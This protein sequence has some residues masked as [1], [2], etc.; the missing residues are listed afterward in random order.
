MAKETKEGNFTGLK[1][2]KI[3]RLTLGGGVC[4]KPSRGLQ[5]MQTFE[6]PRTATELNT[7]SLMPCGGIQLMNIISA[8]WWLNWCDYCQFDDDQDKVQATQDSEAITPLKRL[9][10][11][12]TAR[13]HSK[14]LI[15]TQRNQLVIKEIK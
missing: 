5:P 13:Q 10:T 11:P 8:K 9:T 4:S 6:K 12:K 2:L 1:S 14:K 7:K 15:N 3:K